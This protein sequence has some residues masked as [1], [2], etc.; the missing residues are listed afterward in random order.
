MPS[1]IYSGGPKGK[2]DSQAPPINDSSTPLSAFMLYFTEIVTLLVMETKKHI[3]TDVWT[4]FKRDVL[5]N[6]M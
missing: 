6:L 2:N 5:P 3:I 4:V 1:H